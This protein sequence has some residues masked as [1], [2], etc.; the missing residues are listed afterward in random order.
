M[1]S[2]LPRLMCFIFGWKAI[3]HKNEILGGR[4]YA[5]KGHYKIYKKGI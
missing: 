3:E 5:K 4:M 2:S 1:Q